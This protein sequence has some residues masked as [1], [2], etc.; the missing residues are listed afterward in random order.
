MKKPSKTQ[1]N[2]AKKLLDENTYIVWLK[3]INPN[4]FVHSD[5][6]RPQ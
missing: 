2:V 5:L 1:I 3:S 4:C 6:T